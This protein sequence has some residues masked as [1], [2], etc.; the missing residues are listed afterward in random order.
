M[1]PLRTSAVGKD[2]GGRKKLKGK[3]CP[4]VLEQPQDVEDRNG[5]GRGWCSASQLLLPGL[6]GRRA[7]SLKGRLFISTSGLLQ[8]RLMAPLPSLP[9]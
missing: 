7:G 2:V 6:R 9:G 8:H 1:E 4:T 5:G 3:G